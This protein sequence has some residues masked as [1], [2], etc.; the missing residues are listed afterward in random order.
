MTL[1]CTRGD[2]HAWHY[3]RHPLHGEV[4]CAGHAFDHPD[5]MPVW[6]IELRQWV[7]GTD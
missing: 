5:F 6:L 4:R 7:V 1:S 2:G 3:W